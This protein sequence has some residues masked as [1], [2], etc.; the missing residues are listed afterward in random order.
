MKV[1]LPAPCSQKWEGM[2]SINEKERFCTSC[3]KNIID[4]TVQSDQQI[5]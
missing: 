4:F 1:Q 2:T 5:I 3:A